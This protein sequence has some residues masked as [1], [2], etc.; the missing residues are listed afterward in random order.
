ML[1]PL[2]RLVLQAQAPMLV[3]VLVLVQSAVQ[4]SVNKRPVVRCLQMAVSR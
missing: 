3:Q 4:I 2:E 1:E